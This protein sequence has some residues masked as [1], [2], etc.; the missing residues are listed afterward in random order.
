MEELNLLEK[1]ERIKAPP[2]FEQK[3]LNTLSERKE[4]RRLR[5]RNLR[6]SFAGAFAVL[7]A[8]FV[9]LNVFVLQR[10]GKGPTDASGLER[11]VPA[12]AEKGETL[13]ARDYLPIIEA[14]DYSGEIQRTSYESQTIYI[15]EQVSEERLEQIKY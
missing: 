1:L 12:G 6:F 13:R 14:V 2:D 9:V 5:V 7:L 8:C 3:V 10:K 15:L 4:K 11:G